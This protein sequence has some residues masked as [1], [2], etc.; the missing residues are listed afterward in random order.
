M[1]AGYLF[2]FPKVGTLSKYVNGYAFSA[3]MA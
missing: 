2:V 3:F 1:I